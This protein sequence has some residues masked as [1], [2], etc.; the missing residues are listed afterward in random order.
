MTKPTVHFP[1]EKVSIGMAPD[2]TTLIEWY[3]NE[4]FPLL[5]KISH[6]YIE[7]SRGGEW[8][9]VNEE[10]I[11]DCMYVDQD[12]YRCSLEVYVYYR[13]VAVDIDGNEYASKPVNALDCLSARQWRLIRDILRKEY[14]RMI[15]L[16]AGIECYLLKRRQHGPKCPDCLDHDLDQVVNSQCETCYGTRFTGGYYNAIPYYIDNSLTESKKDVTINLGTIDNKT[17]QVRVI[18]CP[19]VE[20]YDLIVSA[21]GNKRFVVRAVKSLAEVEFLP[22]VYSL[23]IMELSASAIQYKVPLEQLISDIHE[24]ISDKHTGGWDQDSITCKETW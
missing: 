4:C 11:Q 7:Y 20:T 8:C 17:R 1:F 23:T 19:Q 24:D 12:Q 21:C 6:F 9:R 5:E 15:T 18:A 13:V 14:L 22:I 3:M 16:E 2:G 10:D